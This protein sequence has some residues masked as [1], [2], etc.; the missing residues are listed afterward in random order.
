MRAGLLGTGSTAADCRHVS[1]D[2]ASSFFSAG[3]IN[4]NVLKFKKNNKKPADYGQKFCRRSCKA[5]G[6]AE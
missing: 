1:A 4:K 2:T 6:T 5:D 3:K